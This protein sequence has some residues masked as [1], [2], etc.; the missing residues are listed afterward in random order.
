VRARALTCRRRN[1]FLVAAVIVVAAACGGGD[2]SLR[3]V[4]RDRPLEVGNITL[5]EVV[6]DTG[7]GL[8]TKPFT[9]RAEPGE[10]LL[11]YFGFTNCPDVCPTT[12]SDLRAAVNRLDTSDAQRVSLAMITVDPARDTDELLLRYVSSFSDRPHALRTDDPAALRSAEEAFL[13]TSDV[14]IDADGRVEVAHTATTFVV[15]DRGLVLVEWPF[16]FSVDAIERDLVTL[17]DA[18]RGGV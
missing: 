18:R 5:P 8:T 15:D 2:A 14:V 17:L 1:W 6:S 10:L 3:G 7:G 16:G 4:V 12:L 11:V 9:L 13:A